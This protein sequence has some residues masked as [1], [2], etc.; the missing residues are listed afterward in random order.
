MVTVVT[1]RNLF[2]CASHLYS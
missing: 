2:Y 1:Y